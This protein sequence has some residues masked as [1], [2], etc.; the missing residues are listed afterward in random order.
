MGNPQPEGLTMTL[1]TPIRVLAGSL[2]LAS[3]A[4][5]QWVSPWWLILAAFVGVNL[6]QSAFTGFCP[7]EMILRKLGVGQ[8]RNYSNPPASPPGWR[9]PPADGPKPL[10]VPYERKGGLASARPD[11]PPGHCL[12]VPGPP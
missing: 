4:L 10:P 1:E 5:A 6:V 8:S 9:S 3:L 7:A 12:P 11:P 2:V